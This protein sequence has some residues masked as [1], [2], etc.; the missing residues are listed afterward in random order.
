MNDSFGGPQNNAH[1]NNQHMGDGV[2]GY[3]NNLNDAELFLS[4]DK[5]MM[6]AIL[7]TPSTLETSASGNQTKALIFYHLV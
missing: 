6:F 7:Y 3:I 1:S 4:V 2:S 5:I